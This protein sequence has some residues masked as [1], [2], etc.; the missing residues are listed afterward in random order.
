M[1]CL[2][3]IAIGADL[4]SEGSAPQLLT[5]VNCYGNESNL[6]ECEAPPFTGINCPTSG[7]VCQGT[8]DSRHSTSVKKAYYPNLIFKR[9]HAM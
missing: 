6:L 8:Y 7:A 9:S 2:G 5:N 4:F 1:F 3:A